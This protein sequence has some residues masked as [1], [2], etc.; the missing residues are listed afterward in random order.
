VAHASEVFLPVEVAIEDEESEEEETSRAL[1]LI[2]ARYAAG[3]KS[4]ALQQ[5]LLPSVTN[6]NR[7]Q[8]QGCCCFPLSERS[9]VQDL[10]LVDPKAA[11][12]S[13]ANWLAL[14]RDEIDSTF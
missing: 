6:K 2:R 7:Q 13:L 4:M 5:A 8:G 9:R 10:S 3:W 14:A 12:F 1:Q 11:P